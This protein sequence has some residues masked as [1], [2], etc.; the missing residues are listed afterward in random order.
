MSALLRLFASFIAL[1][2]A[3]GIGRFSLTPQLPH[4]I[5]E[6]QIDLTGA[7]LIAAANY[8]GYLIG[9][10]DAIRA[11]RPAQVRNRLLSGLWLCVGLT[12]VSFWAQG[13]WPHLLLR[14]GTGVASAWVMVMI[15]SL[16]QHLAVSTHRPRLGALVFAGPGVG[17]L[18]T[19]L[20][21][22]GANVT[23]Q[24]SATLWLIYAVAALI[25]LLAILPMLPTPAAQ[26]SPSVTV[27]PSARTPGISRLG[28]IYGLYGL[29]YIIPATFLSQMANA[30]F[31][32][33]W[34]ADLFWPAFGLCAALG[35]LLISFRR[36]NPHTTRYWLMGGL[37]IQALGVL[38]CLLPSSAG[39]ALG[40]IL[41]GTPFLACMPLVMQRS[42]DLAPHATQRNAALLTACFAVGQLSGPLLAALSS[43]FS[44]GLQPALG[45]AACGLLVAGVL[46]LHSVSAPAA[47][48]PC[49]AS[50]ALR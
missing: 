34:Q 4:L 39:L 48:A 38:A 26:P 33:Q 20:L 31:Q 6:G 28:A 30:R 13:F 27:A 12:F 50:T 32:G 45:V 40:V 10:L 44:G 14:F 36:I 43:H 24:N 7:G 29:G 3:M 23:G 19:G 8:L 16:S 22:L 5:S 35:V 46:A 47:C 15:T 1:V 25:M 9:A 42:R 17:V 37:W 49:D 21:A 2:M 18:L 11:R 41:C